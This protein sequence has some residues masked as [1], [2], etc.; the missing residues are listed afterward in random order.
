[1]DLFRSLNVNIK[2]SNQLLLFE[3]INLRLF[4]AVQISMDL[5][6]LN[7]FVIFYFLLESGMVNE[8]IVNTINFTVAWRAGSV[9]DTETES[10]P[11]LL[12]N[13][14]HQSTFS[15]T[16]GSHDSQGLEETLLARK[17]KV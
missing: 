15:R 14:I 16:W 13:L 9:G 12:E 11:I 3:L 1:M 4:W 7:K 17:M 5:A 8:M 6:I 2:Q 10:I